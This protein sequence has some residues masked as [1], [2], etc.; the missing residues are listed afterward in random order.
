MSPIIPNPNQTPGAGFRRAL[1]LRSTFA[2]TSDAN[3]GLSLTL[4]VRHAAQQPAL[5]FRRD[6]A[7]AL[8]LCVQSQKL[9][10]HRGAQLGQIHSA[11][12]AATD[13]NTSRPVLTM[14]PSSTATKTSGPDSVW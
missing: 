11:D 7:H 1:S 5:K 9:L 6:P 4:K 2:S 13:T 8:L 14:T 3:F 10:F 12:S